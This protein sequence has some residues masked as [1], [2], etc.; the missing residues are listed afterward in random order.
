LIA[1]NDIN[2]RAE[3]IQDLIASDKIGDAIKL[4]LGFV[5]DFSEEKEDVNEVIVIS[6]TYNRLEKLERRR[7]I[8]FD[9]ASEQRNKLLYQ[10][11]DI[12]DSIIQG[13]SFKLAA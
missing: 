4:L 1:P 5:R 3:E 11:L 8:N 13:L 10:I 7:T 6:Q 2:K 12:I 9:Q